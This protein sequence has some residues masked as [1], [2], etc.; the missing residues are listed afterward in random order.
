MICAA[1]TCIN[2]VNYCKPSLALRVNLPTVSLS[3]NTHSKFN[4]L[5]VM[6]SLKLSSLS[7]LARIAFI[8]A[9]HYRKLALASLKAK[10]LDAAAT[11]AH[12]Y[13][14]ARQSLF[15]PVLVA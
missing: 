11:A 14:V 2:S 5:L 13:T 3:V 15:A 4:S 7:P 1:T 8:R 10:R 9:C 12:R 6:S